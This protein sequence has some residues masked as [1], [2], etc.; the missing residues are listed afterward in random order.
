MKGISTGSIVSPSKLQICAG[1]LG[2]L[3][4]Q[5][6]LANTGMTGKGVGT[7]SQQ[8]YQKHNLFFLC[9]LRRVTALWSWNANQNEWTLVE[10]FGL[11]ECLH[12]NSLLSLSQ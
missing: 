7:R 2:W 10:I 8:F 12:I 3:P 5:T 11:Y 4:L 6:T 9:S 1:C